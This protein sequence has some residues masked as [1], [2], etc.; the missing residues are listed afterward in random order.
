MNIQIRLFRDGY[1]SDGG[2]INV[3]KN[4]QQFIEEYFPK[5][6]SSNIIARW[7]DLDKQFED[8]TLSEDQY[9]DYWYFRAQILEQSIN[10]FL[11]QSNANS[12]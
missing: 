4:V 2:G 1:A 5:Y 8:N 9:E 7:N 3:I 6:S 11:K 10:N 12:K